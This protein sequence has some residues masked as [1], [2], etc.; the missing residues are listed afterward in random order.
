[1]TEQAKPP[2]PGKY[3]ERPSPCTVL[4][5][6]ILC[7]A[8]LKFTL[9]YYAV[10]YCAPVPSAPVTGT[11]FHEGADKYISELAKII[12]LH[13]GSIRTALD[14][15]CGVSGRGGREGVSETREGRSKV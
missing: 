12:P 13:N 8:V 15:G 11:T 5:C 3:C 10:L 2:S 1:V 7:C 9:L 14:T 6:P 4:H